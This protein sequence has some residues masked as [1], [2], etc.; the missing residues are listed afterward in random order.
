MA[1]RRVFDS[2]YGT[3]KTQAGK[4]RVPLPPPMVK[5][6]VPLAIGAGQEQAQGPVQEPLGVPVEQGEAPTPDLMQ[7]IQQLLA[8]MGGGGARG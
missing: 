2:S 6:P 3:A 4:G 7:M 8:Q 5:A 1:R